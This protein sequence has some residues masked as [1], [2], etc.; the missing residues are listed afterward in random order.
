MARLA[1][2]ETTVIDP[3][4]MFA[5]AARFDQ[6]VDENWPDEALDRWRPDGGSAVVS[7]THDPKLDDPALERAL[8]SPAFYNGALGSRKTHTA[9]PARPGPAGSPRKEA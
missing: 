7:L 5:A 4:G 2:Y 9:R 3:R 8:N 6:P 1:G